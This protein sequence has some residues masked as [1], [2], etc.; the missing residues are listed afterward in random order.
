MRFL[1]KVMYKEGILDPEQKT[2]LHSIKM[3]GYDKVLNLETGK[4]F[5]L[6]IDCINEEE[7]YKIAGEISSRLLSNP[8]I[9]RFEVE[10]V[11]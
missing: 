4:M 2:I 7:G 3:L 11:L 10:K 6:D 1:I 5:F 9:E 8:N